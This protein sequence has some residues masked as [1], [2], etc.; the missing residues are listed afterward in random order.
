M[1][2]IHEQIDTKERLKPVLDKHIKA[3]WEG[4]TRP[5][6]LWR[7]HLLAHERIR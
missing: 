2:K 3:F 5:V 1:V 7:K 6:F 4:N